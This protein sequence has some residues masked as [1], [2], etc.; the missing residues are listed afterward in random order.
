MKVKVVNF[1][2]ERNT[3]YEKLILLTENIYEGK[4]LRLQ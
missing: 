2:F 3:L 4:I 1:I